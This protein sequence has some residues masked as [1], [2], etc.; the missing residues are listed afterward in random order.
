[1]KSEYRKFTDQ[2]AADAANSALA[3][4]AANPFSWLAGDWLWHGEPRTF[5][6]A[7]YGVS[8]QPSN[9]PFLIHNAASGLWLLVLADPA[10][11]GILI[12]QAPNAGRAR[13]SGHVSISEQPV[14]LRQT[15][16]RLDEDV[17]EIEN[18]RRDD[19][20]WQLWDRSRLEGVRRVN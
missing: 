18:E 14:E 19:G 12:G 4:S 3:D 2:V 17:V 8:L 6:L 10:A 20:F 7:P 16:R 9:E 11:F 13:F 15:W 5:A 1:L